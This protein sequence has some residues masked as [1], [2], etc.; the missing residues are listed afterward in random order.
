MKKKGFTLSEVLVTLGIVGVIAALTV[1]SLMNLRPDDVKMK[2]IKAYGT[3]TSI[4]SDVFGDT[5]YYYVPAYNANGDP[6][7]RGLRCYS[8][9]DQNDYNMLNTAHPELNLPDYINW[10]RNPRRKLAMILASKMNLQNNISCN[11]NICTFTTTDGVWF[12]IEDTGNRHDIVIDV[13]P[14]NVNNNGAN[15]H[16][17]VMNNAPADV[18]RVNNANSIKDIDTF[19]ISI[20]NTTGRVTVNDAMGQAFLRNPSQTTKTRK[21]REN[22]FRRAGSSSSANT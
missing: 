22:A 10:I 16:L 2:F 8:N 1:P 6:I 15:Q 20:D 5:S 18:T 14:S 19:S 12:R 4:V 13:N 17:T 21:E 9:N 7:C 11:G 3:L